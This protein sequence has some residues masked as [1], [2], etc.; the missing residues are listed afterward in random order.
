MV[1]ITYLVGQKC[2]TAHRCARWYQL[3]AVRSPCGRQIWQG[4][5]ASSFPW[6]CRIIDIKISD[7]GFFLIWRNVRVL[8]CLLIPIPVAYFNGNK[9]QT[10][11]CY[12]LKKRMSESKNKNVWV[13]HLTS[14]YFGA[15]ILINLNSVQKKNKVMKECL[16]QNL[17]AFEMKAVI[18]FNKI[19]TIY[20]LF[21]LILT[22]LMH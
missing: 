2:N 5:H 13:Q 22:N 12:F 21:I 20:A 10:D 14:E 16:T 17:C 19:T 4:Y 3:F 11:V 15:K 18:L 8:F 6:T 1:Y 7:G 9:M